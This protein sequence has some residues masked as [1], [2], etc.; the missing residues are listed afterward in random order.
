MVHWVF[1][2]WVAYATLF[3]AA[4]ILAID[5]GLKMAPDVRE[6]MPRLLT[7][8]LLPFVPIA[9][10]ILGPA[11]LVAHELGILG[12]RSHESIAITEWPAEYKPNVITNRTFRNERVILDGNEYIACEFYN[13]TLV[14]NGTTPVRFTQ[15]KLNGVLL[16]S[17]KKSI[18]TAF[19]VIYGMGFLRPELS[20]SVPSRLPI[21]PPQL[22]RP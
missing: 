6:R 2:E 22:M 20:V 13:V 10:V 4:T 18:M 19:M 11:I 3:I 16:S 15:N 7:G 21:N 14:Y 8:R 5:Q 9:L 12:G 1:W 17:D